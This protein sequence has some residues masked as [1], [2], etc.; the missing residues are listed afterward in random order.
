MIKI[1]FHIHTKAVY[2]WDSE[3]DFSME[4][5]QKY[6]AD[7]ALDCIAITNHNR[8]DKSQF[9]EIRKKLKSAKVLPGIEIHVLN[10]H[11][12]VI[13]KEDSVDEIESISRFLSQKLVDLDDNISITEFSDIVKGKKYLIIPH[14]YGKTKSLSYVNI[15]KLEADIFVG[16]VGNHKRFNTVCHNDSE[17]LTPVLFSD[18][19][20]K[21]SDDTEK[22]GEETR[23][24]YVN[25]DDV[26][27]DKIYNALKEKKN[28]S[29]SPFKDDTFDLLNGSVR[30]H[31][32]INVIL[33]K[34]STG[35]SYLLNN[36]YNSFRNEDNVLYIRQFEIANYSS[37]DQFKKKTDT[38]N[39]LE[40]K[41]YCHDI[42]DLL[43]FIHGKDFL[44]EKYDLEQF[45]SSLNTF[46]DESTMS[47]AFSKMKLF[48]Y[49]AL[50]K[51]KNKQDMEIVGALQTLLDS[52]EEHKRIIEEK[53]SIDSI[54]ELFGIFL[55][56]AKKSDLRD[57][58]VDEANKITKSISK[59]LAKESPIQPIK[60]IN[61]S[62]I[63]EFVYTRE[64]LNSL[65][66]N[67]KTVDI[68][69][70]VVSEK[71]RRKVSIFK[72]S[73]SNQ[74][75][76]K[77]ETGLDRIDSFKRED[78][79]QAFINQSSELLDLVAE[80]ELYRFFIGSS[81]SITTNGSKDLSGGEKAEYILI[82][83]LQYSK[84]RDIVLI[85]E[86][87]SSFDNLYLNSFI[88]ELLHKIAQES[89][90]FISTHNNNL[91]VSLEPDYY[92]YHTYEDSDGKDIYKRFYGSQSAE[93]LSTVDGE[94]IKL[95]DILVETMEA[96]AKAYDERREKYEIS[97]DK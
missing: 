36:I 1:D 56:R 21:D 62:D 66:R 63:Y 92:I 90:V 72:P 18:L 91:G 47:N 42:N 69:D 8:F 43:L 5:L 55:A 60:H 65:L 30:G 87:E 17:K 24:T 77:K 88:N 73:Y 93:E 68:I 83:K 14:Y 81:S 96:S 16:E 31:N 49:D 95:S 13:G 70:N 27:F 57:M 74:K 35:K 39:K 84:K 44:D 53:V 32:G 67:L 15:S 12:L 11:V 6:V 85:D 76:Y 10:G 61:F 58:I 86:M 80:D 48:S 46:A 37:N 78:F 51:G 64:K 79:F 34:R 45:L 41:N 3:F 89:T 29:L 26:A 38:T 25:V 40:V 75:E 20:C 33:G 71:F 59:A 52:D 19:R 4:K 28:V 9:E 2:P 23:Y 94:T 82:E 54:R 22:T 7:N 50:T 97:K